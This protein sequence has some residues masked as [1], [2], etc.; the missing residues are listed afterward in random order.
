VE[1]SS[2]EI[3]LRVTVGDDAEC[4]FSYSE[5]GDNFREFGQSFKTTP[6]IWVGAKVGLFCLNPS[7]GNNTAYADVDWFRMESIK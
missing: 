2:K 4:K 7:N 1:I 3:Y 6:G 5:E